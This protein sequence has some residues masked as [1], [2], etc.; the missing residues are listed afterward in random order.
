[1]GASGWQHIVAAC[2][3][4]QEEWKN[5]NLSEAEYIETFERREA[6]FVV[7]DDRRFYIAKSMRINASEWERRHYSTV[8][9]DLIKLRQ[10]WILYGRP[11]TLLRTDDARRTVAMVCAA[12]AVH[13]LHKMTTGE[14]TT[15]KLAKNMHD[16]IRHAWN[17]SDECFEAIIRVCKDYEAGFLFYSKED[18]DK[19]KEYAQKKK[20]DSNV[21]VRSQRKLMACNWLRPLTLIPDVHYLQLVQSC[22]GKPV[23]E[24]GQR[25]CQRYYFNGVKDTIPE[26]NTIKG[27]V[28]R[29]RRR[30]AVMNVIRWL[31]VENKECLL[32]SMDDFFRIQINKYF[33]GRS[34]KISEFGEL[35]DAPTITAW[36]APVRAKVSKLADIGHLIPPF[37]RSYYV[38]VGTGGLG[39]NGPSVDV[40]APSTATWEWQMHVQRP[41]QKDTQHSLLIRCRRGIFRANHIQL[42]K[43]C[44]W[45]ID[46]RRGGGRH[47]NGPW[48]DEQF[49]R[50][51]AQ[52]AL[53]MTNIVRWNVIFLLPP[54]VYANEELFTKLKLPE[55]CSMLRGCWAFDTDSVNPY[56]NDFTENGRLQQTVQPIGDIIICMQHPVGTSPG[57][58]YVSSDRLLPLV[59]QDLWSETQEPSE[60]DVLERSPSELSKLVGPYLPQGWGLVVCSISTAICTILQGDF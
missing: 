8:E 20:L 38:N 42:D 31:M 48:G 34:K 2:K 15:R 46:C 21:D 19:W 16:L 28:D 13:R 14:L 39:Y 26:P 17:P 35:L 45:V 57:Q 53:W 18:E 5:G 30:E 54:A 43:S 40:G 11:N 49:S 52:L 3:L 59:F 33:A 10:L 36:S 29:Y 25:P 51:F 37:I 1:M 58:N 7:Y 60:V 41:G 44:L 12:S 27:A 32:S 24:D 47:G 55:G 56:S 23:G 9:E 50:A 4:A 6:M 22:A